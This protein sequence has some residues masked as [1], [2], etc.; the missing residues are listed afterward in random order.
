[1]HCQETVTACELSAPDLAI[2]A[3]RSRGAAH[4]LAKFDPLVTSLVNDTFSVRL[5]P[6][7]ERTVGSQNHETPNLQ[8]C[9]LLTSSHVPHRKLANV[10][11]ICMQF[12]VFLLLS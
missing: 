4:S 9:C 3:I 8:Q 7:D 1:M 12:A 5:G 6:V 11:S 10:S 2:G